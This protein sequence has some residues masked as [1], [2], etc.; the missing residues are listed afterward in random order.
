[1]RS[2]SILFILGLLFLLLFGTKP[3]AAQVDK[4]AEKILVLAAEENQTMQHLHVLVNRIGGRFRGSDA[5]EMA[6]RWTAHMFEKFGLEVEVIPVQ[7]IPVGFNRGPWFG[8]MLCSEDGMNLHFV[9]PA[10]TS[11]TR[12]I[13]RGRVLIEPQTQEEFDQIRGALNG[14]WVLV[15]GTNTNGR[16]IDP[17]PRAD[18][19]RQATIERNNE[20]ARRNAENARWNQQNPNRRQREMEELQTMPALFYRQMVEAGILGTIQSST[21]PLRARFDPT[22]E[23]MCFFNNL[24]TVPDIKLNERQFGL[25]ERKT[26]EREFFLLEF[27]IRNHFRMGPIT[28]HNV[29]G[30]IRGSVY[31]NEYVMY[32]GHLDSYCHAP[33]AIDNGTG[34]SQT[35]EVAR[36]ISKAMQATGERPKRTILFPLWTAEE[37]AILG[38]YHWVHSNRDRWPNIVNY[39]NRDDNPTV[40]TGIAVPASWVEDIERIAAPLNRGNPEFP[41]RVETA[42]PIRRPTRIA[43]SDFI[44]FRMNGIPAIDIIT[45][46][47]RGYNICYW[48]VWHSDRD[49]YDKS[50]ADYME[51]TSVAS[52]ILVWGIANL[53]RRLPAADVFID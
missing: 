21:I 5:L 52:A 24:P 47:P 2:K 19:I 51:H 37:G 15:G 38:S 1:M 26:R 49:T 31:P 53:E 8:R 16:A 10:F 27:D 35:L 28:H 29:I 43:G 30:V 23:D 36:L 32:G 17:S 46:D 13:Q 6:E 42:E 12:G 3:L 9:T 33:G 20:I 11:G 45:E 39:F 40:A 4:T 22:F 48:D 44:H 34:I 7:T 14:A 50:V 18:S 25:I 41:F